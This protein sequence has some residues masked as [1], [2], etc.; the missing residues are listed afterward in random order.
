MASSSSKP[1]GE[2]AIWVSYKPDTGINT[3]EKPVACHPSKI[4]K[5]NKDFIKNN[6]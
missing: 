5:I 2:S 6:K 3:A 1:N 4:G